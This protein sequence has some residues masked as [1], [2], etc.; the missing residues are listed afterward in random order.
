MKEIKMRNFNPLK[1]LRQEDYYL[2]EEGF[3][4]FTKKYHLK[5]GFCCQSNC[6]NCPYN[7]EKNE[8]K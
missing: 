2:S 5:R 6:I 8:K 4:I 1:K 7:K 3:I